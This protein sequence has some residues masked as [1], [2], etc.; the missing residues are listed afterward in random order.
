MPRILILSDLHYACDAEQAREGHEGRVID[1]APVRWLAAAYRRHVWL[2]EPHRQNFRLPQILEASE[3]P[4]WVVVNGDLTLDTAF[5]G[6]SD[7]AAC[8]SVQECLE[9]LRRG[10]G[11]RILLCLGDHEIGKRSLFGGAG[12]PRVRSLDIAE[13]A[14]GFETCWRRD[15][16]RYT[17]IGIAS[18]LS[19]W[20]AFAAE[21]LPE[22]APEWRSRVDAYQARV[23]DLFSNLESDRRW[24]LFCHDPTAL[25]Y[26]L[27]LDEVRKRLP[28]LESTVLGHLHSPTLFRAAL[29]LAWLP[30]IWWMGSSV[31][32]Y[33]RALKHA[34]SWQAFRP[35]LCPSPS[36]IQLFKD[37]GFLTLTLDP[38]AKV[39]PLW[40]RH[41]LPWPKKLSNN[42]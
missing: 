16:G 27:A 4:D 34:N 18:T 15:V 5:V 29:R 22:E 31:R 17:L 10:Y 24:I 19:A 35:R 32:R 7:A 40:E 30:E 28:Q 41:C 20:P 37:G 26:L 2:A 21:A 25:N 33:S 12:G 14:L 36:G 9:T 13:T 8:C 11:D 39:T 42:R 6:V 38:D 1:N 3:R 23:K